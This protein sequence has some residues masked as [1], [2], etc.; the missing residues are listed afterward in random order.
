MVPEFDLLTEQ[1]LG[2]ADR[3]DAAGVP[4]QLE[5]YRGAVHSFL[6]AVSIAP[7]DSRAFD[8]TATRLRVSLS[9]T[10]MVES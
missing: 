7:L 1:S 6:E 4:V 3:L 8:D 10:G 5:I 2:L 9:S